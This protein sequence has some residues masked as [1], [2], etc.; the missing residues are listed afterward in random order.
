MIASFSAVYISPANETGA[1]MLSGSVQSN[2]LPHSLFK[3]G[4]A[5][6]TCQIF[7]KTGTGP[8]YTSQQ[9]FGV[10]ASAEVTK[11]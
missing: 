6:T 3:K 2:F 4:G 1:L 8:H 10:A 11:F 5:A 9:Q 7:S